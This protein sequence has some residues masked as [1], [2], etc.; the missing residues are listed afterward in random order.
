MLDS[1]CSAF[2]YSKLASE[3]CEP[4]HKPIRWIIHFATRPAAGR[5]TEILHLQTCILHHGSPL[6][7]AGRRDKVLC[8]AYF[9]DKPGQ[10]EYH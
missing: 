8:A 2:V 3:V 4:L 7:R 5:C 10:V 1:E 6:L 9:R